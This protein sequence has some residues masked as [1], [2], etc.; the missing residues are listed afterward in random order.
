MYIT[1]IQIQDIRCFKGPQGVSLD[2]GEGTFAGW[3]VFAGRNGS[4]KSTLL[5][6]IAMA[7]VGPAR[8]RDLASPFAGWVREG[9][10]FGALFLKLAPETDVD[11]FQTPA[12]RSVV[13]L[14]RAGLRPS[15]LNRPFAAALQWRAKDAELSRG[16]DVQ[17]GLG[18]WSSAPRGWFLAGYGPQ[19][20][21]GPT[22]PDVLEKSKDLVL[23][24]V[25]TLF[26]QEAT[27]TEAVEWLIREVHL[28]AL[29]GDANFE[30]LKADVLDLLNDGLL[31]DNSRVEKVDSGG[32]WIH[33]DG[34]SL[35]LD[36]ISDGYRMVTALVLDIVRRLHATYGDL[37]LT[38]KDGH[39]S[40]PL[41]GVVLIDEV[42]EHMHVEWQQ[43]IGHWLTSRFPA[44]QFLV[45]THSPFICQAAT[46]IIRLP[47]PGETEGMHAIEGRLFQSIV[48]GGADDAV[49]S[50]LF[51]L[52]HAHSPEAERLRAEIAEIEWKMMKKKATD[53]DRARHD[54]INRL[55]PSDIGELA[56]RK[57][58]AA[59]SA[60]TRR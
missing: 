43:R 17:S 54:E 60:G 46:R 1:D 48:N 44:L 11:H 41:P 31:P 53:A 29:E 28:P 18:P 45:T 10:P 7:V 3:T 21:L 40:C 50:E 30:K 56:D 6:A 36:Q 8:A 12:A 52:E 42:E 16:G 22:T 33:R 19:R 27:L 47:A 35:P 14:S 25:M 26:R 57:F 9:A 20:R 15:E 37:E 38:K 55:L 39:L 34:I 2:R 58:R 5:R 4:G 51:G 32:L 23:S 13:P 49:M 59:M 24:R